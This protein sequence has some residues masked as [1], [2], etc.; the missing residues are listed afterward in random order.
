[1][2]PA[3]LITRTI[4]K[5]LLRIAKPFSS[6]KV[7]RDQLDVSPQVLSSLIYRSMESSRLLWNEDHDNGEN[8]KKSASDSEGLYFSLLAE[9][10]GET[11]SSARRKANVSPNKNIYSSI[12]ALGPMMRFPS[13]IQ[14]GAD[15]MD[16]TDLIR[17]EFR[18]PENE[19]AYNIQARID[20]G[21]HVLS[22]LGNKLAWYESMRAEA[23]RSDHNNAVDVKKIRNGFKPG[24]YFVAH[25]LQTGY[26]EKTVIVIL[27]HSDEGGTYGLVVNRSKQK[28]LQ[29]VLQVD[30]FPQKLVESFGQNI[31]RDG[32]PV[33]VSIQM[34]YSCTADEE[35]QFALEGNVL[36]FV[37]DDNY[38]SET[39]QLSSSEGLHI[40]GNNTKPITPA[41]QT[42]E[43]IFF[44]G[45]VSRA[46]ELISEQ[47]DK[48]EGTNSLSRNLVSNDFVFFSGSSV[49]ESGQLESEIERGFWISCS[50]PPSI[51]LSGKCLTEDGNEVQG[52]DLWA[53]MVGALGEGE[54]K[55][56]NLVMNDKTRHLGSP[57]DVLNVYR[58]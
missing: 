3:D 5:S 48:S 24:A 18:I 45:N 16:I 46:S 34:M 28:S 30:H 1:M 13:Q 50:G 56:A 7:G 47:C 25:P 54:A 29:E 53:A 58:G 14:E 37:Q 36:P 27:D 11:K 17:R 20:C 12:S 38:A 49:W 44:R 26:F 39:T 10:V 33:H 42:D 19:H 51:A 57:S 9:F 8:D 40:H 43:A 21:F 22:E 15:A 32:G 23:E 6:L 2:A 4:Y 31:V 35:A 52:P 55:L 41:L